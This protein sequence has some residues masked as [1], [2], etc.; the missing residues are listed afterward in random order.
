[1]QAINKYK[2]IIT[3]LA[4]SLCQQQAYA[5]TELENNELD[6]VVGQ[7]LFVADKITGP[8]GGSTFDDFTFYR[9]GLDVELG[10]NANV[11]KFQLG[12]NGVNDNLVVGCDI[13]ID[14]FSFMGRSG[15]AQGAAATS[16][17]ILTRPYF[18]FA[19]KNDNTAS[20]R[21]IVGYKIGSQFADGMMGIGRLYNNGEMNIEEDFANDGLYNGNGGICNTSTAANNAAGRASCHS[22]INFI[23]GNLGFEM[24]GYTP[25]SVL[26][27]VG[28][29]DAC[30]GHVTAG[31]ADAIANCGPGNKFFASAVG[32]RMSNVLIP[33][34]PLNVYN[35]SFALALLGIDQAFADVKESLKMI[36]Q[37][38]IDGS[39]PDS[40]GMSSQR[41]RVSY[42]NFAGTAFSTPANTGWWF[43]LP[44]LRILNLPAN[45]PPINAI[46]DVIAALNEG[47]NLENLDLGVGTVD[48]CFG[49]LK[50]C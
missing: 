38:S 2:N 46:G 29:A 39:V 7:A 42:P 40:F 37:I 49:T 13:D 17:F 25:I 33:N 28:T 8:A 5:W 15:S 41:E 19:I 21:E 1:M 24:S 27:G 20:L 31:N 3:V 22:G 32:T 48:N 14:F 45:A 23:S 4:L 6:A 12:C 9:V 16:S 36:H 35:R 10:L 34:I 44:G 26:G 11:N 18:E 47:V 30:F 50:F 43:N